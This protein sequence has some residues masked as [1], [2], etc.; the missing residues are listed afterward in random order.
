VDASAGLLFGQAQANG[1]QLIGTLVDARLNFNDDVYAGVQW[2]HANVRPERDYVSDPG[3]RQH[4]LS[5]LLGAGTEWAGAGTG[6]LAAWTAIVFAL[7]IAN[8][9]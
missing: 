2:E 4:A 6:A 9:N 3:G 5:L 7:L 1:G 8:G